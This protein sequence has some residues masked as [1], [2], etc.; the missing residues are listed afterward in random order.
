MV[1]KKSEQEH[2]SQSHDECSRVY[3]GPTGD[4]HDSAAQSRVQ[5]VSNPTEGNTLKGGY[6]DMGQREEPSGCKTCFETEYFVC[7][8]YFAAGD[9]QGRGYLS[10]ARPTTTII[11][12]P[13]T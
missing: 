5:S 4:I 6:R 9:W 3:R 11:R 2:S 10:I 1:I 8:G 12:P 13:P 7:I